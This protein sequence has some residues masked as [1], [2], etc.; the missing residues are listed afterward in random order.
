MTHRTKLLLYLLIF[1]VLVAGYY[2]WQKSLREELVEIESKQ[3]EV[4]TQVEEE[5]IKKSSLQL[6]QKE[7]D[8]LHQAGGVL[9]IPM[10]DFDNQENVIREFHHILADAREYR[11]KFS[12]VMTEGDIVKRSVGMSFLCDNYEL[13][14]TVIKN[15]YSCR[16]RCQISEMDLTDPQNVDISSNSVKVNLTVTFFETLF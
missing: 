5:T 10:A 12:P 6:M 9:N 15:L 4:E 2:F 3:V 14:R 8:A 16:Y 1:L 11:L 7:L 13:A